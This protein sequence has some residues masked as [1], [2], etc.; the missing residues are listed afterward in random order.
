M[1]GV[2]DIAFRQII[3]KYGKPDLFYTEFTSCDGL[4]SPGRDRLLVDLRFGETDRP[5]LAHVFGKRPETFYETA[6]L[7]KTL[8]FDGVDINTGCPARNICGNGCGAELIR[9]PALIAEIIAACKEG[10]GGLPVSVKTRLGYNEKTV[11]SWIGHLIDCRPA[12]I[13]IH[14]RTKK[15]MSKVPADWDAIGVGAAMARGTGVRVLGNGDVTGRADAHAK[16]AK[17]GLD[18]V[19]I[20][21]AIFGNPWLFNPDVDKADLTPDEILA[22]M[23]EHAYLFEDLLG[24]HRN[25]VIMRKHFG[26]YVAGL[27]QVKPLKVALVETDAADEVR[28][29][30]LDYLSGQGFAADRTAAAGPVRSTDP[31]SH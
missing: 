7:A 17:H 22:V 31:S 23:V 14:G 5:I 29:L 9:H 11:E 12:A 20:G 27:P 3:A 8:G 18:G 28:Q 10:G 30:C 26:S 21:R 4:C 24:G 2:T 6:K 16:C 1:E 25:F 13:A 19:L 15:E